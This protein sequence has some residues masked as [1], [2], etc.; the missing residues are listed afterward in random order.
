VTGAKPRVL[1]SCPL[2]G[3][4]LVPLRARCQVEVGQRETGLGKQGLLARI[5]GCEALISMLTDR[6]DVEVLDA[7]PELR[8]VANHAV[9]IDNVD[10]DACRARGVVVSNTPGVLTEATADFTWALILATSR[11]LAEGDRLARSGRWAGWSPT[12]L[13][14]KPV[15]GSTLGLIGCGRIGQ[16]V[17]RRARGFGARVVYTQRRRLDAE[18]EHALGLELL[19]LERLLA[20]SDIVSLHCPHTDE[21][22]RLLGPGELAQMKPGAILINTA[23]GGCVDEDALIDA[24]ESGSLGAVGLDVFSREPHIPAALARCERAVL[25]PHIASAD[26]PARAQMGKLCVDAVLD[27]LAGRRPPNV[28]D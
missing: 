19:P 27:V 13:L 17:A 14:G 12:Q 20:E 18:I 26:A 3:D 6:I 4:A 5:A 7:G 2:A 11:R 8:V 9:G 21:T 16:A 10:L 24:L 28:V 15:A 22:D 23:R 25:T 1:V